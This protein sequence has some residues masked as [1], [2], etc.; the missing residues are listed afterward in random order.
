MAETEPGSYRVHSTASVEDQVSI[1]VGTAIWQDAQLRPRARIGA[2]CVIGKGVFVDHDVVIG[3]D[4]KV[5]NYA[6]IYYGVE[7]GRGV[8]VGPHVVFTNDVRPRATNS[9][10]KPLDF[11]EWIA[12]HSH[13]GNGASI[14]AN[15]TILPNVKIGEWAMV[16]AG[17]VVTRDVAAFSLVVGNP[18][19]HMAWI[20]PCGNK[21]VEPECTNCG[22]LPESHP[23]FA[24]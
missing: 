10:F 12:G 18:A 19:R 8:F 15:S 5:Q 21:V 16:A 2:R 22:S 6:C 24:R 13:V 23:L 3:D 20:C 4:C 1:G 17:S 9:Q 11:G 14:G 7:I